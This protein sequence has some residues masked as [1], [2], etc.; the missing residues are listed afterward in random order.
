MCNLVSGA[1]PNGS[2]MHL[3]RERALI[4]KV[5]A[6]LTR[7]REISQHLPVQ[8][9]TCP[10]TTMHSGTSLKQARS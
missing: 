6:A 7:Y 5:I 3:R 9:K 8:R 1:D 4:N 2:L 10:S